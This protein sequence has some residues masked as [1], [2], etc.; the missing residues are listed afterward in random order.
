MSSPAT[1]RF[2]IDFRD[3]ATCRAD[4]IVLKYTRRFRG[5]ERVVRDA[6]V[7]RGIPEETIIPGDGEHRI[8]ESNGAIAAKAALFVGTVPIGLSHY[9][10]IREF[11]ARSLAILKEQLPG[12]RHVAM[13]IHGVGRGLDETECARAQLRGILLAIKLGTI[14]PDLEKI[15]ICEISRKR[16]LRIQDRLADYLNLSDFA[17]RSKGTWGYEITRYDRTRSQL[18]ADFTSVSE[19]QNEKPHAFIAMPFREELDDIYYY[20]IQNPVHRNGLLCERV[21]QTAY[22]GDVLGQI[23]T[24]IEKAKVVIAELTDAS[25]NVYLEVGY[26]WGLKIPTILI[27]KNSNSLKFDVRNQRCLVYKRIQDLEEIL[28]RELAQLRNGGRL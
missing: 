28:A 21:D 17:T 5:K 9:R 14:P 8:V 18:A 24:R 10:T 3:I 27:T 19:D 23:Q 4:V 11:T 15:T 16:A 1:I 6:L 2:T 26:A 12:S 20:G 13:T 7:G 22:T 25:P